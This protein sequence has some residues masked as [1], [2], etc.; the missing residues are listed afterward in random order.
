MKDVRPAKSN[1]YAILN[2]AEK[3]LSRDVLNAF[4]HYDVKTI[5]WSRQE[6]FIQELVA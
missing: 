4:E 2:D 1:V 6:Q 5:L 3:E